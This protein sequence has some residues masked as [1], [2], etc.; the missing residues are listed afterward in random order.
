MHILEGGAYTVQGTYIDGIV[1]GASLTI[2]PSYRESYFGQ[3]RN[4]KNEGL[5]VQKRDGATYC[6]IWKEAYQHGI[7]QRVQ[8][9]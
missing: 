2:D 6:G 1:S 8:E 7:G 9:D 5:G 4:N 3:T